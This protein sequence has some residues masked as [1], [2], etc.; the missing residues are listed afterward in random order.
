MKRKALFIIN[1]ISGGK[2]K[3]SVPGMIKQHLNSTLFE[4][5][6]MFTN[7]VDHA[8]RAAKDA[9]GEYD[10]VVAVG[11]DGTVNEVASGI[12][13]S[14][15]TLG[16]VPCGSGNGL[17]RF[18]GIPMDV[19]QSIELLNKGRVAVIDSAE[20]NGQPFFNIAGMGFDAHIGEVFA[21]GKKRGFFSYIKSSLIE[22]I[23]YKARTY[24]LTV[25]G[26]EH[27]RQAFILSFANSSQYG[28]NAHVAPTASVQD[29]LLDV[30]IV[31]PFPLYRFPAMVWHL[32]AKTVDKSGFVEIIKA[33]DI[34]VEADLAGP[35]HLDGEPVK[36]HSSIHIKIKP[37]TLSV[38]TGDISMNR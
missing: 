16:I 33:K 23:N 10:L 36:M 5:T 26:I 1:P 14:G 21:G 31:K 18:L 8:R 30:C 4:P 6:V 32:F 12:V 22:I 20:A 11:G 15:T 37:A 3:D 38:I 29:G 2:K 28:N 24:R 35:F 9:V 17:S 7:A 25:D 27:I 19:A 34:M 13:G